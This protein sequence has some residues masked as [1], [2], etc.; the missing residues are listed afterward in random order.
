MSQ[1]PRPVPRTQNQHQLQEFKTRFVSG[2]QYGDTLVR[3]LE[4]S[5]CGIWRYEHDSRDARRWWLNF[6]LPPNVAE[7]FDVPLEI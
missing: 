6:T 7:M 4:R 2:T 3:Y 5:E 1:A